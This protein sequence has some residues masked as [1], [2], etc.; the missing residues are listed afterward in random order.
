[1][2]ASTRSLK[3]WVPSDTSGT[4]GI[5]TPMI[6]Q[7][8]DTVSISANET[9]T[10]RDGVLVPQRPG[11]SSRVFRGSPFPGRWT[12]RPMSRATEGLS[13]WGSAE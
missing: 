11:P 9:G 4:T 12:I 2:F 6:S 10:P 8:A 3:K 1:M 5:P 13:L 7:I